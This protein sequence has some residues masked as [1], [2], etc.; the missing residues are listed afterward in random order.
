M[1][2][3]APPAAAARTSSAPDSQPLQDIF[4]HYAGYVGAAVLIVITV[5]TV[6]AFLQGQ[7]VELGPVKIGRRRRRTPRQLPQDKT[8]TG[9]PAQFSPAHPEGATKVYDADDAAKFYAA[10]A[11]NYD[12]GN[13]VNLLATHMEVIALISQVSETK[14]AARILDLGGGTGHAVAT[15][16]FSNASMRWTYVDFSP[17]MASQLQQ[18]LAGRP[19]YDNLQVHIEDINHAHQRLQGRRFDIVLLNLVCSSM[20]QLPDLAPI[21]RLMEPDGL[22]IISDID[23]QYTHAHPYYKGTTAEGTRVALRT[24]AVQPLDVLAHATEAGLQLAEMRK[25]G[26][27]ELSYSFIA[28]FASNVR[29]GGNRPAHASH[30]MNT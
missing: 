17:A 30:L 7:P 26:N 3:T 14:P 1:S 9:H 8:G 20:P 21:A 11:V 10:I 19:L 23:P 27:T 24:R 22:L 16:F 13:S 25:I 15:H 2:V 4:G 6:W 5:L 29:P 28:V 12:H 18:H